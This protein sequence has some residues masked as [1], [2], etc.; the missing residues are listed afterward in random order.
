MKYI[1]DIQ[2]FGGTIGVVLVK[3]EDGSY[4][5]FIGKSQGLTEPE[6]ALLI[7]QIGTKLNKKIAEAIFDRPLKPYKS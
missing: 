6:D 3:R 7:S 2:W 5:A 1:N 4:T